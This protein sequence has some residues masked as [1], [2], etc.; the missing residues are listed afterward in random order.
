[1]SVYIETSAGDIVVDLFTDECPQA[2]QNFLKLCKYVPLTLQIFAP[3]GSWLIISISCTDMQNQV[4][5]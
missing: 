2:C 1:M 4:L 3:P 5:P